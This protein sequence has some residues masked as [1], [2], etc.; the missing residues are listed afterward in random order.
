MTVGYI[1]CWFFISPNLFHSSNFLVLCINRIRIQDEYIDT[2]VLCPVNWGGHH[3]LVCN[4]FEM[5]EWNLMKLS[6]I[7]YCMMPLCLSIWFLNLI[8]IWGFLMQDFDYVFCWTGMVWSTTPLKLLNGLWCYFHRFIIT[9]C[10]CAPS[11]LF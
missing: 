11:I 3:L 2:T 9:L 10:F 8:Y 1:L 4:S 7:L 5:A 6:W